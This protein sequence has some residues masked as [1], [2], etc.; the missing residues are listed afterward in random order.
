MNYIKPRRL[1]RGDTVAVLSPSSGAAAAF[2]E[3]YENG[4]NILKE[5]GLD[6][7]EYPTTRANTIVL[8]SDPAG[9][10]RDLNDAFADK[11]V[12]A[13]FSSIGG[14]D[15]IRI[16]P[17]LDKEVIQSNPK[18]LMGFS[19]TTTIHTL[20]NQLGIVSLY[21]PSIMAGFSQMKSLPSEFESH[22]R[23]MLFDPEEIYEL[24]PYS[25]YSEGYPNWSEKTNL[26]KVNTL[27]ESDGWK[28]LQG[29]GEKRGELFGGCMEVLEML[30]GTDFW[31]S[32]EFWNGK[33]LCIETSENKPSIDYIE[34]ALRNYG[35]LG[36]FDR[37]AGLIFARAR[38][39]SHEEKEKLDQKILSIVAGEFNNTSLPIVTNVDFGH[40][41]PQIVLPLGARMSIDPISKRLFLTDSWL[42]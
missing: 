1:K 12:R 37:A 26:G 34:H 17:Y 41:D 7:K 9:R 8:R 24:K 2:P 11:N 42:K 33:I 5:W 4:L 21:G 31:P 30:K 16:L 27:K 18:I 10:A 35:M 38:D 40:T 32:K 36:V 23:K 14:N 28:W 20:L 22:V 39:F 29:T 25:T 13:I 3:I 19:D 15:S 6:V